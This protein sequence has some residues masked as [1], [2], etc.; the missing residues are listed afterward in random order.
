MEKK[1]AIITLIIAILSFGYS[2]IDLI[3]KLSKKTEILIADQTGI[4]NNKIK[5]SDLLHKLNSKLTIINTGNEEIVISRL[6]INIEPKDIKLSDDSKRKLY[7]DLLFD[8]NR[9]NLKSL[10]RDFETLVLVPHET[11]TVD[12]EITIP[13]FNKYYNLL[14]D[15]KKDTTKMFDNRYEIYS[16]GRIG[17]ENSYSIYKINNAINSG[18]ELDINLYMFSTYGKRTKRIKKNIGKYIVYKDENSAFQYYFLENADPLINEITKINLRR[19]RN[20][21]ELVIESKI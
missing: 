6:W 17:E 13:N 5:N 21:K 19:E 10:E 20:L 2:T 15:I 8:V 18:K 9:N 12:L 4:E 1:I 7:N 3:S 11:G 14:N 16:K